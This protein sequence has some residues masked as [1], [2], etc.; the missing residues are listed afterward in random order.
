M[1]IGRCLLVVHTSTL[2]V[3][4]HF[5]SS[6][7]MDETLLA[8]GEVGERANVA[9]SAIRYYERLGLLVADART[10]GQRRYRIAT[11]RRLVFIG[12][13]QDA[14]LALEDIAGVLEAA[15]VSEWKAVANHDSKLWTKRSPHCKRLVITFPAPRSAGMT[16]RRQTANLWVLKSIVDWQRVRALGGPGHSWQAAGI[17]GDVGLAATQGMIVPTWSVARMSLLGLTMRLDIAR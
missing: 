5:K 2:T 1:V 4:L 9:T 10:S 7:N 16:T 8:I 3:E 15:N 14:G 11:L 13:L 12:M 17:A 6:D